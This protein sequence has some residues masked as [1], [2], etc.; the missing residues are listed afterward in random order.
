MMTK[1][2][3]VLISGA[4]VAGPTLAYWLARYGFRPVVVERAPEPREGGYPIDVRGRAVEVARRMG[5]LPALREAGVEMS[6]LTFVDAAG[7]RA[8]HVD[9]Q[10]L[11]RAIPTD[12]L[13]LPRGDLVKILHDATRDDVEYVFDD[14]ITTMEQDD[15]GVTVAFERGET[16]RF[17]LVIGADGLHSIVRRLAFGEESRFVHHLGYYVAAADVSRDYGTGDQVVL[18]NAPGKMAG[19]YSYLDRATAIFVFRAPNVGGHDHRDISAQ[20]RLLAEAFGDRAWRVPELLAQVSAAPDFYFDS[21]SQIRMAPWSRGRVS[22]AGDAA[23]C[24][25]LLSGHGTT[26]A[27]AGAYVL[28]G[29]LHAAGG[30]HRRA[31]ARYEDEHR[32][33]VDEGLRKAGRGAAQLVPGSGPAIWARNQLSHLWVVPAAAGGLLRRLPR[34]TSALKDYGDTALAGRAG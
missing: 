26:L 8:G 31:F 29:E 1:N 13:E 5:V 12:D 4:S 30:D 34:R 11:R 14:S 7:R 21:V 18:Y 10:A 17:D 33:A 2:R 9:A 25:A 32:A 6:E 28:A 24:P 16:R 20:K 22:L 3:D 19:V 15:D 27:M 23:H